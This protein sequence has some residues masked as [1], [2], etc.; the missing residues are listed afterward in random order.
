MNRNN[1]LAFP[2]SSSLRVKFLLILFVA[3]GVIFNCCQRNIDPPENGKI[4]PH[5]EIGNAKQWYD[6]FTFNKPQK[7]EIFNK[8]ISSATARDSRQNLSEVNLDWKNAVAVKSGEKIIVEIPAYGNFGF[9]T[10]LGKHNRKHLNATSSLVI[11]TTP[12][13]RKASL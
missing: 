11:I 6:A 8:K 7:A 10:D 12:K 4:Y 5:S 9:S 1:D 3:S 2:L 13:S